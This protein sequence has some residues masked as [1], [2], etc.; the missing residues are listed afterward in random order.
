MVKARIL[1]SHQAYQVSWYAQIGTHQDLML[2]VVLAEMAMDIQN[3]S[4]V[5]GGDWGYV[6]S[7]ACAHRPNVFTA[8]ILTPS[9]LFNLGLTSR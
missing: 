4:H 1:E 9:Q 8:L 2:D 5:F 7:Q 6:D 3:Y